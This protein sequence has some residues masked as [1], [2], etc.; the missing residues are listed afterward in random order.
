MGFSRHECRGGLTFFS[1]VDHVLSQLSTIRKR[2]VAGKHQRQ[3]EE[4]TMETKM[5]GL[6]HGLYGQE[7]DKLRE[8]VKDREA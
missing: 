8:M 1:P 5:V 4:G 2:P 6:H 3:E 7:F